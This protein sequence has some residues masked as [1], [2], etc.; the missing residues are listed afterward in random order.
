[1]PYSQSANTLPPTKHHKQTPGTHLSRTAS[2]KRR[3][4]AAHTP[5]V[6]VSSCISSSKSL[7][8]M[9]SWC[10][11]SLGQWLGI[12]WWNKGAVAHGRAPLSPRAETRDQQAFRSRAPLNGHA[13]AFVKTSSP[14]P[15][16]WF[17]WAL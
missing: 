9:F 8:N 17:A 12:S 10:L 2:P 11:R 14:L 4:I 5:C 7:E 1:M 16:L 6:P 13:D 15:V 3:T